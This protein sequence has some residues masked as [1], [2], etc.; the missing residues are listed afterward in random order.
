MLGATNLKVE[1]GVIFMD[2]DP[3]KELIDGVNYAS[4]VVS[5]ITNDADKLN[6]IDAVVF[7]TELIKFSKAVEYIYFKLKRANEETKTTV[8]KFEE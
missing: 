3:V 4:E 5:Y 2:N 7:S 1:K 8:V 6:P